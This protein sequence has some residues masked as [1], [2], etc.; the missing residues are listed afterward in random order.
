MSGADGPSS[1]SASSELAAPPSVAGAAAATGTLTTSSFCSSGIGSAADT[2]GGG[3]VEGL[4]LCRCWRRSSS[5]WRWLAACTDGEKV[6]L[7]LGRYS[8][9]SL[10]CLYRTPHALHSVPRPVGPSRHCG[11]S[12]EP[13]CTQLLFLFGFFAFAFVFV[14][15]DAGC[16]GGGGGAGAGAV[17]GACLV[18]GGRV[19]GSFGVLLTR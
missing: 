17:G 19:T 11:V 18:R 4:V 6:G 5:T 8:G 16:G 15:G 1:S 14:F 3:G 7:P 13:Q 10:P 9:S 2:G 12:V